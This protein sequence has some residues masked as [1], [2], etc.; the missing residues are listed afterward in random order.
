M[1][2]EE[3]KDGAGDGAGDDGGRFDEDD[4]QPGGVVDADGI[5]PEHKAKLDELLTEAAKAGYMRGR[6]D[7]ADAKDANREKAR[8]Q[9]AERR[10]KKRTKTERR[11]RFDEDEGG[12]P[13]LAVIIVIAVLLLILFVGL[14]ALI[15]WKMSQTKKLVMELQEG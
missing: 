5:D 12:G 2:D 13:S 6:R 1:T 7:E 4:G 11:G 9:S 3:K 10:E 14:P 8:Q 15:L